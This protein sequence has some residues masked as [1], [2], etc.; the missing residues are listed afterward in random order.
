MQIDGLDELDNKILSVIETNARM[1]FSDIGE[2]VGLSRVSVKTRMEAMEKKGI[3]EGYYTKI[4]TDSAPEGRRFFL[5]V[6]TQPDQFENIVD[7]IACQDVIKRVY[8][9]TG[10][11]RFMAEGFA[12][13]R[14]QYENF[15]RNL[16]HD[17][18]G[19][20]SMV[21]MDAQYP[22]KNVYGGVDY[23]SLDERRVKEKSESAPPT[24]GN[25]DEQGSI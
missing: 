25:N 20:R 21:V 24:G 12:S 4:S 11:C 16:R 14:L 1:S 19:V 13:K 6:V 2:K 7:R 8:A 18:K 23:V 5:D 22:I 15:M 17:L 3:I 10:D 9:V